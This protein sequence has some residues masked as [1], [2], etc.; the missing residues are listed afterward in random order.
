MLRR[1]NAVRNSKLW[2]LRHQKWTPTAS[3]TAWLKKA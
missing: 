2:V 1:W 3:I